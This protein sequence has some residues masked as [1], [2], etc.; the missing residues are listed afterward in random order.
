MYAVYVPFA[1]CKSCQRTLYTRSA[2]AVLTCCHPYS[3]VLECVRQ[4]INCPVYIYIY[5]RQMLCLVSAWGL[6]LL[7]VV[8]NLWDCPKDSCSRAIYVSHETLFFSIR[9]SNDLIVC[10][11]LYRKNYYKAIACNMACTKQPTTMTMNATDFT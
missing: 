11:Q 6:P 5:K 2:F 8:R 1:F 10:C 3:I 4:Y 7:L 9:C